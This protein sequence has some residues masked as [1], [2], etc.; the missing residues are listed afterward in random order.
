[1]PASRRALVV[2]LACLSNF[3]L[4]CFAAAQQ[5]DQVVAERIPGPQW[6][7]ISRRAGMI[8]AGTVLAG[9]T[10]TATDH[11][12]ATDR[13]LTT[14][15]PAATPAVQLSLRVDRAIAGVEL[16]QILTIPEWAGARS[17]HR[18]MRSGQH[19]L[20]LLDPLS[21]LGF[22]S[23]VGG[24]LGQTALDPTGKAQNQS[25]HSSSA[26]YPEDKRSCQV[27]AGDGPLF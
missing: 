12:A 21:R 10:R 11:T 5:S 27:L 4:S 25:Q 17:V 26:S 22:T 16:G 24:S 1:M 9:T 3:S 23:P 2:A 18:P 8:F 6:K 13:A 20:I 7:Q 14:A 19:T 15:V